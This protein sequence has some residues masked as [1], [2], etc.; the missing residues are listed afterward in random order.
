MPSPT[1]FHRPL[2]AAVAL[3]ATATPA[4]AQF[5][6]DKLEIHGAI[7]TAYGRSDKLPI[8]GLTSAPT[9]DYRNLTLQLRYHTDEN[10]QVVLQFLNRRI[11]LSPLMT[12]KPDVALH[13]GY[14]QH[15]GEWATI[16]IGRAPM[17]RGLFNETRFVGTVLPL[18][19]PSFEI[20]GEGRETV[21][22]AV[23]TKRFVF[24]GRSSLLVHAFAG[25]N[26]VRT[27][28][29]TT[30]GNSI[31]AFRGDRLVGTQLW[32]NLPFY[33][34]K[35][36][37]YGARYDNN[38]VTPNGDRGEYL[39]SAE[40][41]LPKVT[42]RAEALRVYGAGPN[43]DR[44]SSTGQGVFH[45]TEWLD[46]VGEYSMT[47]NIVFQAAPLVN[48]DVTAT[49]DAV[50]GVT[51]HLPNSSLA[52]FEYHETRG[53]AFDQA[54]PFLSTVG[55]VTSVAAPSRTSYWLASFAVSF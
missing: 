38:S 45:A 54:V 7:N 1:L 27:Q 5:N 3:L 2:L 4:V 14:W 48:V 53:F 10:D 19:R 15:R 41:S 22:G 25:S 8:L 20:Y 47:R 24:G 55:N 44:R 46:L 35:I 29:V 36:G 18:F 12:G 42:V 50:A 51:V 34:T 9:S 31:R 28:V 6:A 30:A 16:K 49:R 26:E 23:A 39:F 11:G 32:L 52:R 13:W 21:D 33:D 37:G 17:P 43:Q 40:S